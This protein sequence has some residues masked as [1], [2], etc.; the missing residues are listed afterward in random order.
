M[1]V[2]VAAVVEA[3]VVVAAVVG[4]AVVVGLVVVVVETTVVVA[5]VVGA[6][7]VVDAAVVVVAAAPRPARLAR[8]DRSD[9]PNV[10][11]WTSTAST[12]VPTRI[13]DGSTVKARSSRSAGA[14]DRIRGTGR[15]ADRAARE[16]EPG[17]LHAVEVGNCA[18]VDSQAQREVVGDTRCT[19]P[20]SEV[21]GR[22]L[23]V[24]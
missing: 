20:V 3:A 7:V 23:R 9:E 13:S 17:D 2:V 19:E 16:V 15:V 5:A 6:A 8:N 1:V 11:W 4:A 18:I 10:F 12:L 14:E 22:V 21:R 24:R